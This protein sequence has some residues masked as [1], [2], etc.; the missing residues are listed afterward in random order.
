MQNSSVRLNST[1]YP[2]SYRN[3]RRIVPRIGEEETNANVNVIACLGFYKEMTW[4]LV[5]SAIGSFCELEIDNIRLESQINRYQATNNRMNGVKGRKNAA[6]TYFVV[7]LGLLSGLGKV[8]ES[9]F[10]ALI[11]ILTYRG[12]PCCSSNS[13][14]GVGRIVQNR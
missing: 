11:R 5:R 6:S 9:G 1:I 10:A 3:W 13:L 12:H 4:I 7:L 8:I 2:L 14:R